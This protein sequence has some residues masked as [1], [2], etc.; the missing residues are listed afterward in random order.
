MEA[1]F[2]H[3]SKN[4][5]DEFI[6]RLKRERPMD[7]EMLCS[8]REWEERFH[9]YLQG[10]KTL[11]LL[12]DPFFKAFF[13]SYIHKERLAEL[14]G[15]ILGQSVEIL[16]VLPMESM[17]FIGTF[18]IM[19]M[20]VKMAD[21]SVVNVEIQKVPYMFPAERIS[22]YSSDLVMR[23][24]RRESEQGRRENRGITYKNLKKVHTIVFFEQSNSRLISG[25]DERMYFHEGKTRFN[26]GI[27]MELLQE[28]HL[29]S[30]DT[31]KKYRYSDIINNNVKITKYDFDEN[32]YNHVVS[33]D[34]K[35]ARLK[36]LSLFVTEDVAD[37]KRLIKVFPELSDI[38]HDMGVYMEDLGNTFDT[39]SEALR[40]LDRNTADYMVD[41]YRKES[42][43]AKADAEEAKARLAK[44]EAEVESA[45]AEVESAK[46]EVESAK[47]EVES[48]KAEL[49]SAKAEV[50]RLKRELA[51]VSD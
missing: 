18:V 44:K 20:V 29:I 50:E 47:A 26:S 42:E 14:I 40:I 43:K 12:Y 9:G 7:Y 22:C 33:D 36:Y 21:G 16:E 6:A 31:F 28:F 49:E 23:Q 2:K 10:K 51:K 13:N 17:D 1:E 3:L 34:I 38:V 4:V 24:Y 27:K 25:L 30:L 45:K 48:T 41:E 19:D 46:A 39:F 15:S 5:Y 32:E 11:P 37:M 35:R 8:N